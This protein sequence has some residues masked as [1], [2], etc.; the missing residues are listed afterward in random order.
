MKRNVN[1]ARLGLLVVAIIWGSGFVASALALQKFTTN[2]ILAFRF[3]IAFVISLIVYW[4]DL[5]LI[6]KNN[7]KSGLIIGVFL[8]LAFMFQTLGLE[9]TTASKNAFLTAVNI[10]VV[11]FLS[12]FI[13]KEKIKKQEILGS[14]IALMGIALI[15][16]DGKA[17]GNLNRGDLLTLV[18]ALFFALQ[19]F[20]TDHYVKNVNPG[21][22]MIGQ[23]GM[24]AALSWIYVAIS[25]DFSFD[26]S[27]SNLTPVLYL[28]IVSTMVA[29]GI[30]TWS[31]KLVDSTESAI[32][33]S[34]EAF[35]GMLSSIIILGE[36]VSKYLYIA[37]ILIFAGILI[38][39]IKPRVNKQ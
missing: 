17:I 34:T 22:I 33:L 11:P 19:I 9:H 2:Q 31:Q 4:K 6:T 30:Q 25:K 32:I 10:I 7:I 16:F 37:G 14:I 12:Y 24:A 13:L 18:C 28:G 39:Q 27:I 5:K 23:M 29:Y 15:S 20:Y 26:M 1:L 8:F 36:V 38:V 3:T 21:I 35:F